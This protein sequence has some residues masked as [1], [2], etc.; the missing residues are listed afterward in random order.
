MRK[1]KLI[2]IAVLALGMAAGVFFVNEPPP[3]PLAVEII[4]TNTPYGGGLRIICRITNATAQ[5]YVFRATVE[6]L[7]NGIWESESMLVNSRGRYGGV[8]AYSSTEVDA[9]TR[10]TSG[11]MR[12]AIRYGKDKTARQHQIDLWLRKFNLGPF[13][14]DPLGGRLTTASTNFLAR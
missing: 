6:K 14:N 13:F 2:F 8:S 10:R 7:S 11:V 4:G 1:K 12:V 9:L 3:A 5:P